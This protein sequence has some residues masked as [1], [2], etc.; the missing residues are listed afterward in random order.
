MKMLLSYLRYHIKTLISY[1]AFAVILTV[2]ALL[3][4]IDLTA[5][6]YGEAVCLFAAL[7]VA[8]YD[9]I[10]FCK[11]LETL[12]KLE[13][14]I[15]TL[16]DNL[17]E[18]K[19]IIEQSYTDIIRALSE[20]AKAQSALD[21][22]KYN[23]M[24]SYYTVWAHQIKTPIA[25]MR[26]VLE[27]EDSESSRELSENLVR[28]EQYAEMVMCYLRL[29]GNDSDFVIREYSLDKIIRQAVKK[30]SSQ[31]IRKKLRLVYDGTDAKVLTDEKWLL[32]V[33]EQIISNSLKYTSSGSVEITFSDGILRIRDSGSGI[34]SDELPRI[35][36]NGF[37]GSNGRTDMRASG[38]GLYLCSRICKKLG[39]KIYAESEAGKGTTISVDL[40][41][42]KF[43][44]E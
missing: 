16:T 9:F 18:P 17:P 31:F 35:F 2:N 1:A 4:D 19:N 28:I 29:D 27:G 39:H 37:T 5:M 23:D 24:I 30:F 3:W 22:A 44:I 8:V 42:E 38:I 12:S 25:A 36:E 41:R 33:T 11:R 34:P 6:L 10:G 14:D 20:K 26:L 13:A 21:S 15:E 40:N 32:F 43:R 7:C